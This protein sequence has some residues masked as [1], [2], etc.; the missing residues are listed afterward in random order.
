MVYTRRDAQRRHRR[1]RD[2]L[3][4]P[5]PGPDAQ[6]RHRQHDEQQDAHPERAAQRLGQ[7]DDQPGHDAQRQPG[8]AQTLLQIGPTITNNGAIVANS[9]QHRLRELRRQPADARRRLRADLHRQRHVRQRRRCGL[10]TLQRPE[11]AGRH[12]R[13]GRLAA[14]T[15]TASTPS[16]ARSPT[17]TRSPSATPMTRQSWSSSAAP[18]ASRSPP[19]AS[20]AAPT[21]NIGSRRADAGLRPVAGADDHRPRDPG[22]AQRSRH[23]DHQPD[24]RHAGRR[25]PHLDRH[26][27]RLG[28]PAAPAPAR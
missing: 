20:I 18:R 16:T 19:A 2:E 25:R 4:L 12:D 5:R 9:E 26:R 13:P 24:R 8:T 3:H 27:D 7:P 22:Y 17:P 21:F 14:L 6:R 28:R 11:R 23:P 10:V 1:H 15:S